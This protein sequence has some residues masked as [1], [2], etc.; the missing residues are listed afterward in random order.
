MGA[1]FPTKL[2]SRVFRPDLFDT[3]EDL[4]VQVID[5]VRFALSFF[6][7]YLLYM[8]ARHF[9]GREDKTRCSK[10]LLMLSLQA[11]LDIIMLG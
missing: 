2:V 8:R 11:I 10:I 3:E 4:T 9:C 7:V 6:V 5:C 1:Y